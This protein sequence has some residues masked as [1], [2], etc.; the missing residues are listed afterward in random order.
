MSRP[1]EVL[2][3]TLLPT[4]VPTPAGTPRP[5]TSPPSAP[6]EGP[7]LTAIA[8]PRSGDILSGE[9]PIFGSAVA[10]EFQSYRLEFELRDN[11]SGE[12]TKLREIVGRSPVADAPLDRWNTEQMPDGLY[13]IRLTVYSVAGI[14][15]QTRVVATVRNSR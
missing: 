3:P 11:A 1:W 14:A 4:I 9:V 6:E 8:S 10:R 2:A 12:W 13:S 7:A 15:S 5:L